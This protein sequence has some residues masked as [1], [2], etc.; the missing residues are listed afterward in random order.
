MTLQTLGHMAEGDQD[1]AVAL[2]ANAGGT[3]TLADEVA[4]AI[5]VVQG[6]EGKAAGYGMLVEGM[7][8]GGIA[9]VDS[10]RLPRMGK[11]AGRSLCI[12][13]SG[14]VVLGRGD[15]V[16]QLHPVEWQLRTLTSLSPAVNHG[17]EEVAV[18]AGALGIGFALIP[19]DAL[20]GIGSH[21]GDH[22]IIYT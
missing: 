16:G 14:K 1:G 20:D 17:R 21:G 19:D 3:R 8:V 11:G 22:T 7:F 12:A 4:M 6:M 13:Q 18:F 10:H 15:E 2:A 5:V 9:H